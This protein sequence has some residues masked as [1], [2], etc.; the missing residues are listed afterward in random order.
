VGVPSE[1]GDRLRAIAPTLTRWLEA[2]YGS[3]GEAPGTSTH[4]PPLRVGRWALTPDGA[5]P[6]LARELIASVTPVDLRDDAMLATSELV[7]NAILHGRGMVDLEVHAEHG[8]VRIE[9]HD[10]GAGAP[11][12]QSPDQ[13]VPN[14]RGL[15]IVAALAADWGVVIDL[16][17][18]TVWCELR[19]APSG[20]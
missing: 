1:A 16:R 14:G 19:S 10:S 13:H 7:T 17:G 12:A 3:V 20:P 4:V 5:T 2:R 18:K 15:Q 6:A 9:V 8:R 11:A